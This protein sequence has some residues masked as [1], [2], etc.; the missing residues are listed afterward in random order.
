MIA[1]AILGAE[2]DFDTKI[3]E[4]LIREAAPE[5]LPLVFFIRLQYTLLHGQFAKRK[6]GH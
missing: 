6:A 1:T 3:L 4:D 2:E 5:R